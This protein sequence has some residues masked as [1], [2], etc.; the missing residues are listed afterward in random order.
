MRTT[1]GGN[2]TEVQDQRLVE[3]VGTKG[4]YNTGLYQ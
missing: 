3:G 1:G 2:S 4:G